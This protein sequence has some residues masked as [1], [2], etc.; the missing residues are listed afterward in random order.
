MPRLIM[1]KYV[2]MFDRTIL[3]DPIIGEFIKVKRFARTFPRMNREISTA[4][5]LRRI[6][7]VDN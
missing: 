6:E 7:V 5:F 1:P 3:F 4:L 2:Y